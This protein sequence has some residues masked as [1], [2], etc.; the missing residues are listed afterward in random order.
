[1]CAGRAVLYQTA[2]NGVHMHRFQIA[3]CPTLISMCAALSMSCAVSVDPEELEYRET[4]AASAALAKCPVSDP[5]C[6]S[7]GGQIPEHAPPDSFACG[8]Y[9]TATLVATPST[10]KH[11]EST[12]L[13]WSVTFSRASCIPPVIRIE[14]QAVAAQ[15][16]M[17]VT[18]LATKR[19]FVVIGEIPVVPQYV[20]TVVTVVLPDLVRIKGNNA[21]WKS[22]LIQAVGEELHCPVE[23]PPLPCEQVPRAD[24]PGRTVLLAHDLDMDLTGSENIHISQGVTLTSELPAA[25]NA[26]QQSGARL[27]VPIPEQRPVA[28]SSQRL[29]PRL[30]TRSRPKPLFHI[31]CNGENIFGDRARVSGF[32]LQGP[33][34]DIEEGDDNTEKGIMV[35]SCTG[36]D[37]SNMEISGW[38]GQGIYVHDPVER[39]SH[40]ND[41]SVHDNFIHH[42]QH[43]RGN[44]Y[45]VETTGG[46]QASIERNVFDFNRHAIMAGGHEGNGYRAYQNLVLSGGGV[47]GTIANP[48]THQFD[49]HG[50]KNC[51]PPGG[52]HTWNCGNAGTIFEYIGNTF[53]YTNDNAIKIRGT[54]RNSAVIYDNVFA[55]KD[56]DDAVVLNGEHVTVSDNNA[57]GSSQYGDYGV[58]DFDGD[59]MDDLFM[60]TGVTWWFSSGGRREWRYLNTR[61]EKLNEVGLGDFDGDGRC[62]VFSVQG[63]SWGIVKRGTGALTPLPGE[64]YAIPFSQL[65]FGDFN[66]DGRKDIF[67]R[68]ND[69]QWW[70]ISPGVYPWTPLQSSS[71]PLTDLRFGDLDGNGVT[72]V[73]RVASGVLYV[74]WDGRSSRWPLSPAI[75]YDASVFIADVDGIAG[76]DLVSFVSLGDF[77]AGWQVSSGGSGPWKPLTNAV[78]DETDD[79]VPGTEI[80]SLRTFFGRFDAW[81]GGDMLVLEHTRNS[82]LVSQG[83][84]IAA[85]YNLYAY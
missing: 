64:S 77:A 47:H 41:V 84:S 5:S 36:V 40:F 13:Q 26:P 74:S 35:T 4:E 16:S 44:G 55:H 2:N 50:D 58:C 30:Y 56:I 53:Q 19:Y 20:S 65:A 24:R 33:H 39:I 45:G 49:V 43:W 48:H 75:P 42:N 71:R 73:A 37:I 8:P 12:T 67:R 70:V 82:R 78:Y 29:G 66:G 59:G 81:H 52:S 38:S 27:A 28:R 32:R 25:G 22:L 15:G 17:V 63:S 18:P 60:A 62:D 80:S 51:F 10:V 68:A 1:M 85:P 7:G 69:G 79:P 46:A 23:V 76:D 3:V 21:E 72:D 34:F 9:R 54:P 11:G 31:Q 83:H 61:R 57:V 6:G 14:G